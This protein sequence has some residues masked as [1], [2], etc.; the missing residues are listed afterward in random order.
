MRQDSGASWSSRVLGW[1]AFPSGLHHGQGT[2]PR[3]FLLCS[4]WQSC[5]ALR[6]GWEILGVAQPFSSALQLL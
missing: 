1:L 2:S 3:V 5:T 4:V 6:S